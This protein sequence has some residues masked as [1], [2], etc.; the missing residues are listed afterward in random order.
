MTDLDEVPDPE[1]VEF[2]FL[3]H[4]NVSVSVDYFKRLAAWLRQLFGGEIRVYGSLLDRARREASLRMKE[5]CQ[6][7]DL[8]VNCRYET[9]TIHQGQ[10]NAIACVEVMAY[11]TAVRYRR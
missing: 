4:G 10:S 8:F 6:D 3:V 11:G 1:R 5:Q 7:A 9:A 2:A